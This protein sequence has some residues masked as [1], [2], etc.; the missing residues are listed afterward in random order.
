MPL[1]KWRWGLLHHLKTPWGRKRIASRACPKMAVGISMSSQGA[2]DWENASCA[3]P[4]M[5]ALGSRRP[6][7]GP[8]TCLVQDGGGGAAVALPMT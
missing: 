8:G 2:G 3:S 7:R 5:A 4:K 1:S 6:R